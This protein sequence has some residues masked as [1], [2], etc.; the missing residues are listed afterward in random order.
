MLAG[1]RSRWTMP[2]LVRRLERLG[3]LPRDR[4]ARSCAPGE[5]G[6][7]RDAAR[8]AS[9]PRPASSTSAW[10]PSDV[11]EAV[12]R[13]DVRMVQRREQLRLAL[14][15]RESLGV[16]REERGQNL[17]RDVA[18]ELGVARPVDFAHAAGAEPGD[19]RVGS[20]LLAGSK[21]RDCV[22]SRAAIAI[23]GVA[24]NDAAAPS[25]ASNASASQ[26]SPSSPPHASTRKSAR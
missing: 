14:E 11:L 10:I 6:R 2:L 1:F 3:D 23:A 16:A 25:C 15:A 19:D 12:D 20:E 9:R 26:R 8:R 4:P 13:R 24:R 5:S 18:T 7:R 22:S 17:D 21:R